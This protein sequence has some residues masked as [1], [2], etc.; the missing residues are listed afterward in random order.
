MNEKIAVVREIFKRYGKIQALRGLSF[1]VGREI[2]GL[3]GPNGAGKTTTIRILMGLTKPDKGDVLVLGLNPWKD[4]HLLRIKTGVLHEKPQFPP[5]LSGFS[6][7]ERI[8]KLKLIQDP[9]KASLE[10]LS[11]FGLKDALDRK[12]GGYSAGMVQRLGLA[13]AFMGDPELV[14]LDE[15][16][17]NLDP[18]GRSFVLERIIELQRERSISV[19]ISTH[20][21]SELEKIC[22]T[23]VF[24]KNGKVVESG[25]LNFLR[26]KYFG[27]V[28]RLKT[29]NDPLV[30][31]ALGKV[32]GIKAKKDE[33]GILVFFQDYEDDISRNL[34]KTLCALGIGIERLYKVEPTLDELYRSVM[35]R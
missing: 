19:I 32:K 35:V 2:L 30:I 15:P 31:K 11:M 28:F 9:K 20:I 16:T 8:A 27:E 4:G 6:F 22:N 18:P 34:M 26:K 25:P 10:A 29:S 17:A 23:V 21:L 7:L 13:Q 24:I 14:I 1:E 3:V 12:I 33:E 5:W